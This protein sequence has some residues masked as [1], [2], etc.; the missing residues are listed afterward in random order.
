MILGQ[1]NILNKIESYALAIIGKI[2]APR[3]IQT[4]FAL[5]KN[6]PVAQL[7]EYFVRNEEAGSSN[8][9]GSICIA[10]DKLERLAADPLHLIGFV[11]LRRTNPFEL[12][13]L[14]VIT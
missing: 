14:F 2:Q 11:R 8:L 10:P 3:E 4:C 5:L 7:V 1:V 12:Y 13:F 6:G 9:P